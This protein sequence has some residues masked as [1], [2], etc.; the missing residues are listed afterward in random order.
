MLTENAKKWFKYVSPN[1]N[2]EP[3]SVCFRN[4][5]T[6]SPS[7][8]NASNPNEVFSTMIPRKNCIPRPQRT[9]LHRT[10]PIV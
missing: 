9:A 1:T 5:E 6:R 2:I 10:Y 4:S 3:A 7:H 8:L